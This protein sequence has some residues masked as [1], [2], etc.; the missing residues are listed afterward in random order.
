MLVL[1]LGEPGV[2]PYV[3]RLRSKRLVDE[4]RVVSIFADEK[5]HGLVRILRD[6]YGP[7][8]DSTALCH[9]IIILLV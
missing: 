1:E 9:A 7:T 6:G 3:L 4:L 8:H 5:G 2:D